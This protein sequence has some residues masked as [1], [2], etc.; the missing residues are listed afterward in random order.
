MEVVRKSANPFMLFMTDYRDELAKRGVRNV[1][2]SEI[3]KMAGEN[4]RSMSPKEKLSYQVWASKNKSLNDATR[5]PRAAE[6]RR[7]ARRQSSTP[8]GRKSRRGRRRSRT[9]RSMKPMRRSRR[10]RTM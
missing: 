5:R 9:S 1:P 10:S 2:A 6:S 8:M 3:S 7:R 4:W